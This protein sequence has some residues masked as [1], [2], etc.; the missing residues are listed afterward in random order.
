LQDLRTVEVH[1]TTVGAFTTVVSGSPVAA[2]YSYAAVDAVT[3]SGLTTKL[4][5]LLLD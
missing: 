1:L 4:N 5:A 3:L 2:V